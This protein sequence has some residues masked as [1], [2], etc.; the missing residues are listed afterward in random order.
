MSEKEIY[1]EINNL[2]KTIDEF[3]NKR[4]FK[5]ELCLEIEKSGK[6][7]F[8]FDIFEK[9]YNNNKYFY[10]FIHGSYADE[11]QTAFS[12]IDDIIILK[13]EVFSSF[14][15]F[16]NVKKILS[17]LNK[18]YQLIDSLQ[19]H[20]HWIFTEYDLSNYNQSIMPI[21]V[22]RECIAIGKDNVSLKLSVEEKVSM[23][24]FLNIFDCIIN[25]GK[26]ETE[27]LFANKCNLYSLKNLISAISLLIPLTFQVRGEI[28][29]KSEAIRRSNEILDEKAQIVLD[30]ASYIRIKWDKTPTY[31]SC[32]FFNE[33]FKFLDNRNMMEFISRKFMPTIKV[34]NL[35]GIDK[36]RKEDFLYFFDYIERIKNEY[37]L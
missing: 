21:A 34:Y 33:I 13:K 18:T 20:G 16:K 17:G 27:K 37:Y 23:E 24:G 7:F 28:I 10:Y 6:T 3:K 15:N 5:K 26:S 12:D 2:I 1:L 30:W 14:E 32:C 36:V 11:T 31:K 4:E 8:P 9:K 29:S 22:F 35:E 19:H 25:E